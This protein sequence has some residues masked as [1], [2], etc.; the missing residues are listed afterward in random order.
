MTLRKI[1]SAMLACVMIF[2]MASSVSA[3]AEPV[4]GGKTVFTAA[5]FKLDYDSVKGNGAFKAYR[6]DMSVVKLDGKEVVKMTAMNETAQ[7]LIDFSYYQYNN[8][9]YLPALKTTDYPILMIRYKREA[10]TKGTFAFWK[11]T[12]DALGKGGANATCSFDA[13]KTEWDTAIIDLS[14]QA[15][16]K[17]NE[18]SI[19]Q[20]RLY[21]WGQA[22]ANTFAGETIY[23]EY[24][25]FFKTEAEAQA[26]VTAAAAAPKPVDQA[27]ATADGTIL[28]LL[29]L[30]S[31]AAA[32]VIAK[33][34]AK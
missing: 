7:P 16:L 15:S 12:E 19:R 26:Y 5:D 33:K 18:K 20:F 28:S 2:A 3:A 30:A 4:A 13:G 29:V 32:A 17:W 27:P 31:S 24:F 10:P 6:I 11:A 14:K 25:G 8:S 34:R 9:E 23:I 21:P 22:A 1:M